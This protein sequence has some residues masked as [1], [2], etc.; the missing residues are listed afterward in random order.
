MWGAHRIMFKGRKPH[1]R[2]GVAEVVSVGQPVRVAPDAD[3]R[4][5]TDR[6]MAA[7]VDQVRRA[8]ELYPQR[9]AGDDDGWWV[10]PPETAVLRPVGVG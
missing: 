8:R 3:V 7:V 4:E 6:I 5:A 1:W 2:T 10:R 9:P